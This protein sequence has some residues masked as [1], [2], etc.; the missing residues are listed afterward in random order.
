MIIYYILY[1]IN[2]CVYPYS[3]YPTA[4]DIWQDEG[5]SMAELQG[6][7]AWEARE[8]WNTLWIGKGSNGS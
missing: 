7:E 5:L 4:S 1:D 8:G 6:S 3:K 2:K